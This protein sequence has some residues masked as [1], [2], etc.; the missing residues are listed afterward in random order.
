MT[1]VPGVDIG[2]AQL[3]VTALGGLRSEDR[4]ASLLALVALSRQ[5]R[6]KDVEAAFRRALEH[7]P[8]G[9]GKRAFGEE[10]AWFRQGD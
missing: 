4:R 1:E 7:T 9:F 3:L 5:H 2:E 8:Q 10:G 6:L